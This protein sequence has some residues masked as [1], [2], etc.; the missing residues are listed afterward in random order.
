MA[1]FHYDYEYLLTWKPERERLTRPVYQSLAKAL[2]DDIASGA[3][4]AGTKLPPQR[5]LANFLDIHFTTVTRAYK[6]CELKGLIYA[7]TGS[8]T[9]VS[10][11]EANEVT[12][13]ANLGSAPSST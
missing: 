8:G 3:L 10:A 13:A 6:I 4:P 12:L 1:T 7:V 11:S 9:F 5:E 2:E